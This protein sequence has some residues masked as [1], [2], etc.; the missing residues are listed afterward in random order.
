MDPSHKATML[1][2]LC[3]GMPTS[4]MKYQAG[5]QIMHRMRRDVQVAQALMVAGYQISPAD[6]CRALIPM[7]QIATPICVDARADGKSLWDMLSEVQQELDWARTLPEAEKSPLPP[8]FDY[9]NYSALVVELVRFRKAVRDC[10]QEDNIDC[11]SY[12]SWILVDAQIYNEL[13]GG[14][15]EDDEEEEDDGEVGEPSGHDHLIQPMKEV[16]IESPKEQLDAM[17]LD[18]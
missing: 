6:I 9:A 10:P 18:H 12:V 15:D 11:P 2:T 7:F 8:F 17:D 4:G 16:T 5:H 13:A 14:L 3:G 1:K